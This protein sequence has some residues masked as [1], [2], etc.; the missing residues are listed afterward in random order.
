[1]TQQY[2]RVK[3]PNSSSSKVGSAGSGRP[4]RP[5]MD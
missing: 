4:V 3:T 1:M 2:S 5:G